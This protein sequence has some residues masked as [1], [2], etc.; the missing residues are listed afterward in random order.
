MKSENTLHVIQIDLSEKEVLR[1][2]TNYKI[3]LKESISIDSTSQVTNTTNIESLVKGML[4]EMSIH[5]M[6]LL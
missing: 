4:V 2:H 6:A 5:T 1:M 3:P